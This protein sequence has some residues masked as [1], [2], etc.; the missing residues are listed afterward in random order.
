MPLGLGGGR[1]RARRLPGPG[2]PRRRR[3]SASLPK[4]LARGC[5][6]SASSSSIGT[7]IPTANNTHE[8]AQWARAAEPLDRLRGQT[9]H[10]VLAHARALLSSDK[11]GATD[12]IDAH[13]RDTDTILEQARPAGSISSG[14]AHRSAAPD[15]LWTRPRGR[16]GQATARGPVRELPGAV[17]RR[18]SDIEPEK[19]AEMRECLNRGTAAEEGHLPYAWR[20]HASSSTASRWSSRE[21]CASRQAPFPGPSPERRG[22][23]GR[24]GR[25]PRVSGQRILL[26]DGTSRAALAE[27][28]THPG[29]DVYRACPGRGW[30]R[31][32]RRA[33]PRAPGRSRST[34]W[35]GGQ[36]E[37]QPLDHG[38]APGSAPPGR[39]GRSVSIPHSLGPDQRV[40][41]AS[42]STSPAL[43]RPA[44]IS[45]SL[46]LKGGGRAPPRSPPSRFDTPRKSA[47]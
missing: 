6:G 21:W 45:P 25:K 46:T 28:R 37:H 27:P 1:R 40:R 30:L 35:V 32:R 29:E 2:S 34:P 17:A 20:S 8:V 22:H 14:H 39:P 13:L 7:G 15:R 12:Y 16:R 23:V 43:H 26:G 36:Q 5:W 10:L 3:C 41:G 18:A 47:T 24:G 33:P 44:P 31:C 11:A 9:T 4:L 19:M 42:E 38:R